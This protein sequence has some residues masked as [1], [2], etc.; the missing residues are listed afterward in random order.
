VLAGPTM[1]L[2]GPVRVYRWLDAW[3]TDAQR[4]VRGEALT[5]EVDLPHGAGDDHAEGIA[6]LGPPDEPRLLVV[7]DSPASERLAG[8]AVLADVVPLPRSPAIAVRPGHG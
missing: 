1:D 2:D 7:Y 5:P 8:D 6:L 4:V 3:S